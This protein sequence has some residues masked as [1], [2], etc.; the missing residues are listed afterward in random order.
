MPP[1]EGDTGLRHTMI[2]VDLCVQAQNKYCGELAQVSSWNLSAF[3]PSDPKECRPKGGEE[4]ACPL[5]LCKPPCRSEFCCCDY[6]T[7]GFA[8]CSP[9]RQGDVIL[10]SRCAYRKSRQLIRIIAGTNKSFHSRISKV[11]T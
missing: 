4:R 6:R 11:N 10:A 2:K 5:G 7:S 8:I 1:N 9:I 3:S